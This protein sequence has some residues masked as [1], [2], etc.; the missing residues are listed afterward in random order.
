[1]L[2]LFVAGKPV[3]GPSNS[4]Q[5]G[6]ENAGFNTPNTSSQDSS[7]GGNSSVKR[8]RLS[9]QLDS[10]FSDL[11]LTPDGHHIA[12]PVNSLSF[13]PNKV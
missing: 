13:T 5:Q 2:G 6:D 4:R 3:A 8:R 9:S 12:Y 11:R 1:M 10:V 7:V